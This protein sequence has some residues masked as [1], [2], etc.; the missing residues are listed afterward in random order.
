MR[1][2]PRPPTAFRPELRAGQ[3]RTSRRHAPAARRHRARHRHARRSRPRAHAV[4][5]VTA[6]R[7]RRRRSALRARPA[8]GDA[9]GGRHDRRQRRRRPRA[10]GPRDLARPRH[11][12]LHADR[13]H[14]PRAGLGRGGR[15]ARGDGRRGRARRGRLVHP[16]RPR[17]RPAPR[18]QRAPARGRA[19]LVASRPTSRAATGSRRAPAAGDRRPPAHAHR[20]GRT[21]SSA[22]QEWLVGHRARRRR[23]ARC[24]SRASPA[25]ARRRACSRRSRAPTASCS[26]PPTRSSRSIR[27]SP[28]TACAPRSRRAASD[29]VAITPMIGADAVK[30][31]LAG[32]LET[33]GHERLGRRRRRHPGARSRPRSCSTPPMRRARPRCAR[34]ALRAACRADADA[35]RRTPPPR[36]PAPR[37]RCDRRR[38]HRAAR[39]A[40][41][42]AGRR[43]RR[44]ARWPPRSA[45]RAACS[46]GDVVVRRAEG[47][48]EG[49]G[50]QRRARRRAA[51]RRRRSRSPATRAIRACSS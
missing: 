50:P 32:M 3:R 2:R 35:R 33:L 17:H 6:A 5:R 21:A 47:G 10:L 18:A 49:R 36:S 31:P 39:A 15:H 8:R 42:R 13:A 22:F 19:A 28:S 29:V 11:A 12:A 45:A 34:S 20:H 16:R 41:A 37:S 44:A 25:R 26:R 48:L 51:V 30:G 38:G 27:S 4:P 43:P 46:D 23:A 9:G 14:P 24:A 1:S 7:G 40:R